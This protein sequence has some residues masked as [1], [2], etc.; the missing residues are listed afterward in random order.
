MVEVEAKGDQMFSFQHQ[1]QLSQ[2]YTAD[3]GMIKSAEISS[4]PKSAEPNREKNS[5]KI[6]QSDCGI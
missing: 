3:P 6:I 4:N 1:C 5:A 2:E